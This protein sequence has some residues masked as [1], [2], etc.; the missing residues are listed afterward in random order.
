MHNQLSVGNK[1]VNIL[2]A[3]PFLKKHPYLTL[4]VFCVLLNFAFSQESPVL[5]AK[6]LSPFMFCILSLAL[7]FYLRKTTED[8]V[9]SARSVFAFI[10]LFF[11][12]LITASSFNKT[13]NGIF[14]GAL[15]IAAGLLSILLILKCTGRLTFQNALLLLFAT[16]FAVRLIYALYTPIAENSVRQHDVWRFIVG[17]EGIMEK[18]NNRRHA[19]YIEY[20]A[21]YLKL[22]DVDPSGGLSQLYHPPFHHIIAGLWLRLNMEFKVDY[23]AAVESIQILTVFYSSSCMITGYKIMKELGLKGKSLFRATAFISLFPWFFL[24][25]GG[26]NNDIL[27]VALGFSAVLMTIRWYKNPKITNILL[28]ALSLGLAMFTKLSMG[29]LAPAIAYVFLTKFISVCKKRESF[30]ITKKG[31]KD[32][33]VLY[34][35]CGFAAFAVIIFPLGIGWQVKN[36][37]LWDMPLTYVPSLSKNADQYVG[38]HSVFERFFG[39]DISFATNP[40]V[41]WGENPDIDVW[42]YNIFSGAFKTGLFGEDTFFKLAGSSSVEEVVI[43]TLGTFACVALYIFGILITGICVVSTFYFFKNK[44]YGLN[45][46]AVQMLIVIFA[47]F[48]ANYIIFCFGYPFTC[49]MNFRYIVPCLFLPAL[50]LGTVTG[51]NAKAVCGIKKVFLKITGICMKGFCISGVLAYIMLALMPY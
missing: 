44:F 18:F 35:I 33:N 41:V 5:M 28:V 21:R 7:L 25:A 2:D 11:I 14:S 15:C 9:F 39:T 34:M 51:K 36:L 43:S 22:P 50:A 24:F 27:S 32:I 26:V 13:E 12:V 17:K 37:I 30:I 40:F 23:K 10:P 45:K 47:T 20:I 19:E 3:I 49:T 6:W 4:G 46:I 31:E 29:L 48:F 1:N 42:E 38:F 16:G 8:F